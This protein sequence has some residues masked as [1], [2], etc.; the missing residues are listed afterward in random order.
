MGTKRERQRSARDAR[1]AMQRKA[2]RRR[3]LVRLA[4]VGVVLMAIVGAALVVRWS[5]PAPSPTSGPA[6]ALVPGPARVDPQ[7][8][9]GILDG[10]PPWPDNTGKLVE[11]LHALDFPADMQM[12]GSA[13]HI[14]QHLEIYVDGLRVTV[15]MNLGIANATTA[16]VFSPI[17]THDDTG[18]VHVESPVA[19][20]F[21]LGE[22]F[23]V[24]GVPLTDQ[25]LGPYCSD[26][27]R[28]LRV[29]V[30]G[31]EVQGNPQQIILASHQVIVVTFGTPNQIPSPMPSTA[32]FPDGM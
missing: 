29:F 5:S 6:A 16:P 10:P 7:T 1:A 20:Q 24:W 15:P 12:E 31:N 18:L 13:L 19:R 25:C 3:R 22:V 11:R 23:D 4:A 2:M 27:T 8:L 26:A 14:H 9:P 17:H 32:A 21:T 30:N 28:T